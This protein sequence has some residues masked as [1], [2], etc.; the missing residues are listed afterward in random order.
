MIGLQKLYYIK[1]NSH[2][3]G[4]NDGIY[5]TTYFNIISGY[6]AIYNLIYY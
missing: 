1:L 3:D 2:F 5:T 4:S 6:C